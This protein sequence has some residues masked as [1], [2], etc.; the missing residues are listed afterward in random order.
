MWRCPAYR[1]TKLPADSLETAASWQL[2][3]EVLLAQG[4]GADAEAA[5]RKCLA[6]REQLL[7]SQHADVGR[8]L[9]G[10]RIT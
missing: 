3:G 8:A 4:K 2:L 7:G 6:A 5:F 9:L 1:S 10:E